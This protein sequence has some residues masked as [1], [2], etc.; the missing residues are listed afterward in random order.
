MC[1]ADLRQ[2]ALRTADGTMLFCTVFL[3]QFLRLLETYGFL[4]RAQKNVAY[5]KTFTLSN[6]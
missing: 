6:P 1:C 5:N 4:Y 2:L 3:R